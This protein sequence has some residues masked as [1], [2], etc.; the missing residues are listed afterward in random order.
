MNSFFKC[1]LIKITQAVH[2][3]TDGKHE[4]ST[5]YLFNVQEVTDMNELEEQID[6]P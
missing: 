1:I 5:L 4:P 3:T 6:Q 2:Q